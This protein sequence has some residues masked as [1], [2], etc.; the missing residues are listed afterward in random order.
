M[1]SFAQKQKNIQ[2]N[3]TEKEIDMEEWR[4]IKETCGMIEV[5]NLGRVR[6]L[7]KG[8]PMLLKTQTDTKGYQRVT[9]TV[10]RYKKTFKI[11]REVAKAFID[12]PNNLPQVNHISGDKSDNSVSN[13][14]WISNIDNAHHAI[15]NGLWDSV[16][17]GSMR[18]NNK[19]KIPIV[20]IKEDDPNVVI[21]FESVSEAE[22]YFNSRHISDA[23]NGKRRLC[24]GY[25]FKKEEV[26]Q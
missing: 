2:I 19:R 1:W 16:F 25:L 4:P 10:N 26:I 22:R 13:L 9:V 15:E 7:L 20:A 24:N 8:S 17:E 23:I 5:S 3:H 11:H 18:E 12:N 6:S 21:R 14:E